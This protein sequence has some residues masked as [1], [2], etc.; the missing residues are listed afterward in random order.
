MKAQPVVRTFTLPAVFDRLLE[1][2]IFVAESVA[3]RRQ[4]HRRHRVEE[5]SSKP[6][7]AAISQ[8][9]IRLLFQQREPIEV[10]LLGGS[11]HKGIEQ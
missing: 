1:H 10:S 11:L 5:T 2:A 6:P 4:L 8:A 3:H 7:E 9:G